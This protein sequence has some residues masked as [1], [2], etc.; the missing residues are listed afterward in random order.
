MGPKQ[1]VMTQRVKVG[2]NC[3]VP[4]DVTLGA[5][6]LHPQGAFVKGSGLGCEAGGKQGWVRVREDGRRRGLS[7]LLNWKV[8]V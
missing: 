2:N 8:K 3:S 5:E 4:R 6:G 7:H 1:E